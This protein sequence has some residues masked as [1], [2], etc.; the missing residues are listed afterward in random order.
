MYIV[1]QVV[2]IN[3]GCKDVV[4]FEGKAR[5]IGS[6]GLATGNLIRVTT[7]GKMHALGADHL[8]CIGPRL[9]IPRLVLHRWR[10]GGRLVVAC[11]N[12]SECLGT[13]TR[14]GRM[15]RRSLIR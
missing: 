13:H 5:E 2:R 11:V 9:G 4:F 15:L 7:D 10:P 8:A 12:S 6:R 3:V 1:M 14:M